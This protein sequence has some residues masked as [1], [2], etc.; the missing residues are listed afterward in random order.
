MLYGVVGN[1]HALAV[2]MPDL[3]VVY[4]A[5]LDETAVWF[6]RGVNPG[7]ASLRLSASGRMPEP[8]Q[9]AYVGESGVL[10]TVAQIGEVEIDA[11]DYLPFGRPL[12]L[13]DMT[14]VNRSDAEVPFVLAA[15]AVAVPPDVAVSRD[16]D[17]TV[18]EGPFGVAAFLLEGVVGL[19]EPEEEA[20]VRVAL[21]WGPT[22]DAV[23]AEL[24]A[25]ES[26][27]PQEALWEWE[28]RLER[29][30]GTGAASRDLVLQIATGWPEARADWL[31]EPVARWLHRP[32]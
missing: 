6:D 17:L 23:R 26:I 11:T 10:R 27:S 13:R 5:A 22:R 16:G 21:A 15:E 28:R 4:L 18:L 2:V 19:L 3:E 8:V 14:I 1:G 12:F 32:I 30:A 24:D 9:Q 20:L 29:E 25:A 31:R 7:G